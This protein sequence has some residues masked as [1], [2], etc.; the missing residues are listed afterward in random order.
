MLSLPSM[1][2]S[3]DLRH[4]GAATGA[5][6]AEPAP[7]LTSWNGRR[8]VSAPASATPMITGPSRYGCTR[9]LSASR[10]LPMHALKAVVSAT[11]SPAGR[12]DRRRSARRSR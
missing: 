3:H 9:G 10:V 6:E 11:V 5:A 7:D 8:A 1:Y 2:Q 4:V 12:C